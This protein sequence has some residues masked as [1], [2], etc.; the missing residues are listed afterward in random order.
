VP[1]NIYIYRIIYMMTVSIAELRQNPTPAFDAV[2]AGNT[3][4]VTR[5][6]KEIGRIVPPR[7]RRPVSG[8]EVMA[9]MRATPL[10]P[11]DTWAADLAADRAAFDAQWRDPWERQ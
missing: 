8:E 11:D 7:R 9:V 2:E 6:R 1:R 10:L 5:Y 3:V 4:I